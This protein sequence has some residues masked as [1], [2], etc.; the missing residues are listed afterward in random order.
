MTSK[1]E[2]SHRTVFFILGLLAL[3]WLVLLIRDILFLLF[4]SFILMSAIRPL[5]DELERRRVPRI[6]GIILVYLVVLA[7]LGAILGNLIPALVVQS[8][9]LIQEFPN[10]VTRLMPYWDINAAEITKQI[11]PLGENL[12]KLTVGI[13]SNIITTVTVFVFTFYFLLERRYLE[14]FLL[15]TL[16]QDVGKRTAETIKLVERSLGAWLLGQLTLMLCVGVLSY[17][18]L[19]LLHVEFALSLAIL[20][21]IL[22]IVPMIGPIISAVPAVL[23]ALTVSPFLAAATVALYFI[24]Q[25]VENNLIIPLIMRRA[26]GLPPLVTIVSL[27]IGARLAGL[28][29]AILSIPV[30]VMLRVI[31]SEI[32]SKKD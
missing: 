1:I 19:T 11:A 25:Q 10:F 31:L 7:L 15:D 6:L 2:I 18:G 24:V 29:G 26:V 17:L 28:T 22:E 21:G 14:K 32:L 5:V 12:L 30:V 20:A 16:G 8:T 4:I 13:F 3:A 27:M 23:V 9:R